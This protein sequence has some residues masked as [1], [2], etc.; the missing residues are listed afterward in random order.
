MGKKNNPHLDDD[1]DD[2]I[3]DGN[4]SQAQVH[5]GQDVDGDGMPDGE[6]IQGDPIIINR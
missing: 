4:D 2:G 6:S 1:N 5:S 3:P